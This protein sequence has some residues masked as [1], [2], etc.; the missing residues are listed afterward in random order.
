MFGNKIPISAGGAEAQRAA[1]QDRHPQHGYPLNKF[2]N[3]LPNV[4]H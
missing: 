1:L 4:T 2:S 3:Q